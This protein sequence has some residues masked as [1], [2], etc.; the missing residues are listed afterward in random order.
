MEKRELFKSRESVCEKHGA[1]EEKGAVFGSRVIW[2]GCFKCTDEKLKHEEENKEAIELA[3]RSKAALEYAVGVGGIPARMSGKKLESFVADSDGK[4][5]VLRKATTFVEGAKDLCAV[6]S[7]LIMCGGV[8][9]GKTHLACAI[10][11]ECALRHGLKSMYRTTYDLVLE[12]KES[13]GRGS[14]RK[15]SQVYRDFLEPDILIL[16]EVGVQFGSDSES[17]ILFHVINK[18]YNSEKSTIVISNLNID[19]VKEYLGDRVVDRLREC[20]GQQLPFKWD[21]ARK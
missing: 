19:G 7:S 11:H 14:E 6:G 15:E 12:I 10:S 13:W 3:K 21:S 2:Q 20:G 17:I 9:T 5:L 8:G 1:Y 4:A 18:R 16:D